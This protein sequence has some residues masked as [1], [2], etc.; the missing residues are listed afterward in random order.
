MT[1]TTTEIDKM[2]N[3][4]G[5]VSQQLTSKRNLVDQKKTEFQQLIDEERLLKQRRVALDEEKKTLWRDES[6]FTNSV[7][8]YKEE[9][10]KAERMLMSSMDRVSLLCCGDWLINRERVPVSSLYEESLRD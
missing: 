9:V 10:K 3:Q 6:K 7:D 5:K 2:K 8:T 1:D 4:F